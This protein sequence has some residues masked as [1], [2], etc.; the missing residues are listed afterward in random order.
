MRLLLR[1]GYATFESLKH[2]FIFPFQ[3]ILREKINHD[4]ENSSQTHKKEKQQQHVNAF[5]DII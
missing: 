4:K 5:E 3:I 2:L 1:Y